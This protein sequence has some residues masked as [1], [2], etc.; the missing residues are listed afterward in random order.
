[1]IVDR[2]RTLGWIAGGMALPVALPIIGGAGLA[3]AAPVFPGVA[4][5]TM[6][7]YQGD[8]VIGQHSYE[9]TGS[10]TA[11]TVQT[12]AAFQGRVLGFRV[13]YALSTVEKWQ[14]GQLAQLRSTGE[15]RGQSFEVSAQR[16]GGQLSVSNN[17]GQTVKADPSVLPT[18]Y[19]MP[20][21]VQQQQ[22][23]DTQRG[24]V[25]RIQPQPLGVGSFRGRM[26]QGWD[27]GGELPIKLFYDSTGTWSGLRFSIM[28]NTFEY[29]R[30]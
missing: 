27:I 14:G 10:Q 22:V 15:L 28:G 13:K 3:Q 6:D 1:M 26:V 21:F 2:R 25:L 5:V 20:N 9:I 29:Q 8:R 17:R 30:V 19:W 24:K 16:Q 23:L 11:P 4:K 18:T 7:L 12:D